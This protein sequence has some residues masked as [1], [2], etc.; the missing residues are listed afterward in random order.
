MALTILHNQ[1]LTVYQ[2]ARWLSAAPIPQQTVSDL[3]GHGGEAEQPGGGLMA[4]SNKDRDRQVT[5]V[6]V[7]MTKNINPS[8][9]QFL[10][11]IL[12]IPE[13]VCIQ[14]FFSH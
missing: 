11:L 3:V 13:S 9:S 8:I 1:P 14:G 4:V 10:L 5:G 6:Q 12:Q 7:A 2:R